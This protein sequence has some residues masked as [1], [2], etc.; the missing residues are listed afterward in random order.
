MSLVA[1]NI[2]G[3]LA[4]LIGTDD[5]H[6]A[7]A[8][9][10]EPLSSVAAFLASTPS[11]IFA[12]FPSVYFGESDLKLPPVLQ[13]GALLQS[14]RM[15]GLWKRH[16]SEEEYAEQLGPIFCIFTVSI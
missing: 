16:L 8:G 6:D 10:K 1:K 9:S 15:N 7:A 11:Q 3:P 12:T 5:V 13:Y 14:S 2:L 4:Q